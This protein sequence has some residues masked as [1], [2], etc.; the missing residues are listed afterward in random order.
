VNDLS[1]TG[2]GD[3]VGVNASGAARDGRPQGKRPLRILFATARYPPDQGGTEIHTYEVARRVAEHGAEVTVATTARSGAFER[4]SREG[5]VRVLRVR[6]WPPNRDYY[7]APGLAKVIR[8]SQTDIIHCQGYHTF[9]APLVMLSA[10]RAGIPYIVTMHSGG[11]SSRLRHRLR[12]LQAWLLRAPLVRARRLVAVSSFEADLFRRWLHLPSDLLVVIPSGVHLPAPR[13]V[14]PPSGPPLILSLGRVESYKGHQRMIEAL[15]VLT[16]A[17]PGI[18]LRV[19]GSGLHQRKLWR[20]AERLRVAH[21]V[22]IASVPADE[23]EGL[24]ELLLRAR[25][26]ASLS[27]Y[28]SQGLA[29]QEALALGRPL[30]V[31]GGTALGELG[32]YPNVRV[33]DR[34]AG[35]ADVSAAVLALLDA[36]P[37]EPPT[38]PTWE[39]CTTALLELY[40]ETVA[41]TG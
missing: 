11:H 10:L 23:R 9:V 19:V 17:R 7:L 34:R 41:E 26:V 35:S 20:L 38:L 36:G 33:L 21:L 24:A 2:R 6:A 12:P 22:E 18:R 13:Q 15:P 40:E 3:P 16:L 29:I 30:L 4:D 5:P 32:R 39:S 27:E 31:S 8:E 25:V 37:V 28:E 14:D 1:Q